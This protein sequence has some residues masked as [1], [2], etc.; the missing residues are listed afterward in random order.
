MEECNTVYIVI[1]HRRAAS[2]YSRNGLSQLVRNSV[3]YFYTQADKN[4][5]YDKH[6][7][8]ESLMCVAIIT[9]SRLYLPLR[10]FC[11]GQ[12]NPHRFMYKNNITRVT[13]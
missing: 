4:K 6:P 13:H 1:Y 12:C 10:P 5:V 2:S 9:Y 3:S 7:V 8:C 11:R